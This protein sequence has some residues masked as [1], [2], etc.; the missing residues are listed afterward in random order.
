MAEIYLVTD[1]ELLLG[2]DLLNTVEAAVRG[3]VG[4]VQL[5][6]KES[7]TR[8]FVERA[9]ALKQCLAPFHVPLIINDR[10][11]VALAADADGVHVGQSDMPPQMVRKLL[12]PGKIVGLSVESP[13]QVLD[14]ERLDVDYIAA[15]PVFSTPTKPDTRIE[16]GLEGLRWIRLHSHHRIVA[17]GGIKPGNA[18]DIVRAGASSLAVVSGICSAEDP[19]EAARLYKRI[20]DAAGQER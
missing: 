12:P 20:A 11:D 5:R 1:E 19:F 13:Q 2:K 3:G 6:E 17:I 14:A 10:V 7:S 18:A 8:L 16:W 15:S 9:I 4:M